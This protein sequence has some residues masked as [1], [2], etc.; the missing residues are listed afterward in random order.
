MT[1]AETFEPNDKITN[2]QGLTR[3]RVNMVLRVKSNTKEENV[4]IIARHLPENSRNL[5][6]TRD[7]TRKE[8]RFFFFYMEGIP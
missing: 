4:N 6:K 8:K 3:I 7:E 2:H 5:P 1:D